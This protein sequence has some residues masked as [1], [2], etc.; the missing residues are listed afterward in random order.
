[1]RQK[2]QQKRPHTADPMP[3]LIVI[4]GVKDPSDNELRVAVHSIGAAFPDIPANGRFF[5]NWNKAA[6]DYESVFRCVL[7]EVLFF[8]LR[9]SIFD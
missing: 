2:P 1:M 8:E 6:A 9:R 7:V 4:H 3:S 5:V